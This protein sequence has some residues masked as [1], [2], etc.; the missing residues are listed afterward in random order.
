MGFIAVVVIAV[1]GAGGGG[2]GGGGVSLIIRTSSCVVACSPLKGS[3]HDEQS[4]LSSTLVVNN[5]TYNK[6]QC[7]Q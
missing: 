4:P 5:K 2:A 3:Q 7:H 6:Q 1:V